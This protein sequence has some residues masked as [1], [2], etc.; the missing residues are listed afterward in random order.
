MID[1]LVEGTELL[2]GTVMVQ[3]R[4]TVEQ[5][6]WLRD[7]GE[8]LRS[9]F[10]AAVQTCVDPNIE[11]HQKDKYNPARYR[12]IENFKGWM[13]RCDWNEAKETLE[14]L[15][16]MYQQAEIRHKL[17][18]GEYDKQRKTPK[19][20]MSID[21]KE[22]FMS[23]ED[24]GA[25]YDNGFVR[26]EIVGKVLES[27]GSNVRDITDKERREIREIADEYSASK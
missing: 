14:Q 26:V 18:R 19:Y 16:L 22:K 20:L 11:A 10:S 9:D 2:D 24:A 15:Q 1:E 5:Y 21:G 6:K 3:V 13:Q 23:I 27:D 8:D 4:F 12:I 7:L 17:I 25:M